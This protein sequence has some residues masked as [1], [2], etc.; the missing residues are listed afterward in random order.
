MLHAHSYLPVLLLLAMPTLVSSWSRPPWYQVGLDLQPWGCQPNN[1]DGCEVSLG[2]PGRWMGLGMN[3]INSVAGV[4]VATTVV[5][6]LSRAVVWWRRTQA[7]SKLSKV[8]T[9]PNAP[10]KRRVPI[11]DRAILLRVLHMLDALLIH[12]ECHLQ[13]LATEQQAQIKVTPAQ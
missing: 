7:Q 1:A 10:R 13:H 5:L 2:C 11:S 4:T 6:V 9:D 3:R 8:T 12:I